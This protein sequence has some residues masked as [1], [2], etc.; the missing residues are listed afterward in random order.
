MDGL[1]P[2]WR[3]SADGQKM[4][5]WRQL[6]G[7]GSVY[8]GGHDVL[9]THPSWRQGRSKHP[10][11]HAEPSVSHP[12]SRR[13]AGVPPAQQATSTGIP[14]WSVGGPAIVRRGTFGAIFFFFLGGGGRRYAEFGQKLGKKVLG[15][16]KK[17]KKKL[18][19]KN[20]QD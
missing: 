5:G 2:S 15:L 9:D 11:S 14:E 18:A 1:N 13:G 7:A 8:R 6:G 16:A 19:G 20:R 10:V 3:A 12:V 17:N 4:P